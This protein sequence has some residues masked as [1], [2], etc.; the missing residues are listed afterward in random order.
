MGFS[1][2]KYWSGLP[3]PSPGDLPDPGIKPGSP[4]L[5][6]DALTF[7]PPG[8]SVQ[9]SCSVMSD[10]ATPW[11]AARQAS[12]SITISRSSLRL[13]VHR[14]RDAIQPSHPGS[15]PSPPAPNL[16]QHHNIS[17]PGHVRILSIVT[18]PVTMFFKFLFHKSCILFNKSHCKWIYCKCIHIHLCL[19]HPNSPK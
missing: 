16:S 5:E 19:I 11:I 15:S 4:A 18:Q 3:F 8:S 7:E 14:V 10:S 13:N 2:Q 6:A 12:L 1:R 9:F 17:K